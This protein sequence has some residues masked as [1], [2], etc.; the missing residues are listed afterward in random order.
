LVLDLPDGGSFESKLLDDFCSHCMP[1]T[2]QMDCSKNLFTN[3]EYSP[4]GYHFL[5]NAESGVRTTVRDEKFTVK[6]IRKSIFILNQKIRRK[7][8]IRIPIKNIKVVWTRFNIQCRENFG[9]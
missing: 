3:L 6:S 1:G 8:P 2:V 9:A 4:Q 5:R 7:T